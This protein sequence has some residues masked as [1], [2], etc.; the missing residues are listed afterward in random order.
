MVRIFLLVFW[1]LSGVLL[2]RGAWTAAQEDSSSIHVN[3]V[4]VQLNVA[5]TDRKGNYVSGLRPED[6]S[7]TEDKI[8]ETIST[9]EEG[10]EPTT[11]PQ[12]PGAAG[13]VIADSSQPDPA[14]S[15][16]T[17]KAPDVHFTGSSAFAGSN[18]FILFDTSNYMYRGFVFAQDAIADFIRS[19]DG[20]SKLAFYSYSRDLSRAAPLTGDRPTV[21]RGVRS[22]VAGDDAAL[23]NSLLLTVKDAAPLKGRKVIVVFSNGPDNASSVPPEDVAELAQSTGTIIYMISTQQAQADQVS[24]AVFERMS[25]ATGGKAYFARSWKDETDAFSSIREDLAHLY[26]LS[27]YPQPN[28]NRGWRAIT[29]KLVGKNMQKYHVRT[30]DGYRILQQAQLSAGAFPEAGTAPSQNAQNK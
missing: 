21:L 28:P 1:V 24:E 22:S 25:K 7:V 17:P 11:R 12:T 5:V 4:L 15:S 14:S 19:L 9:F 6:F 30:R 10:N 23:Y 13:Q 16:V 20:V 18:V 2:S 27:Y 26:A 3:V 8:P 29:V